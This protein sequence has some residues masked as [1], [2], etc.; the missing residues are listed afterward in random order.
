VT[1]VLSHALPGSPSRAV[2]EP[3][4]EMRR[5]PG[6]KG[7]A[8]GQPLGAAL[9]PRRRVAIAAGGTA[10]HVYPAL[11]IAEAFVA[12]RP[13][14]EPIFFGTDDGF[15]A[16]LV[17]EHGFR[18][19]IVPALP[20]VNARA[21]DKARSLLA[22]PRGARLAR[23][24]LSALGVELVV[25]LGG[26][27]SAGVVLAAR[28]LGIPTLIHEC[29]AVPGVAN[30]LLARV[31][32][33]VSVSVPDARQALGRPAVVTGQPVR[34]AIRRAPR[35][36]R[37]A[38]RPL[39][40]LVA[41][42]SLGA[43]ALN[44]AAPPLLAALAARGL[45]LEV[46]HQTGR[47]DPRPTEAAYRVAGVRARVLRYLDDV[48]EAYAWADLALA[49]CGASTLAELAL[50][51][52]PAILVPIRDHAREHQSANAEALV[53]AG[54]AWR[55][56]EDALTPARVLPWLEPVLLDPAVLA[57]MSARA[58]A[59]ATPGAARAVVEACLPLLG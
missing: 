17:P 51:G 4:I 14:V 28:A 36:P 20:F 5:P 2:S 44:D 10:G 42:G 18:L 1:A 26:F 30:E 13:D 12:A 9:C 40:V 31:V 49:R 58:S 41:G 8:P 48:P 46:V 35:P 25:G 7:D 11:A 6:S 22:V 53:R 24:R 54:A 21:V 57:S 37:D 15:E 43:P 27:T 45:E 23:A 38:R 39:R 19:E 55:V 34:A 29:N 47:S 3:L 50:T 52:L 56:S 32:D 16:R 59:T 33:R